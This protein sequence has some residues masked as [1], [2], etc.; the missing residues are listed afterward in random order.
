[1]EQKEIDEFE[2]DMAIWYEQEETRQIL[3]ESD[4]K[5]EF[6]MMDAVSLVNLYGIDWFIKELRKRV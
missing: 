4:S 6:C 5:I 1:M 2:K 3:A